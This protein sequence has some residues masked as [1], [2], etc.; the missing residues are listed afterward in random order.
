MFEDLGISD[1]LIISAVALPNIA[2]AFLALYLLDV[3]GRRPLL[4]LSFSTMA[5]ALGLLAA[6][7]SPQVRAPPA[8]TSP[9][10]QLHLSTQEEAYPLPPQLHLSSTSE[11]R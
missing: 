1:S 11:R 3:W 6:A 7:L 2:G 4:Q 8:P 10:P 9:P 5:V